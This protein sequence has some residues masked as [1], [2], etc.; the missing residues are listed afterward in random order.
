MA[1]ERQ[2]H[3]RVGLLVIVATSVCIALVIRFGDVRYVW[4][5]RYPLT[6]QLEN[7]AGLYPTASVLLS[8]LAVGTVTQIELNHRDGGVNVLVEVQEGI[9]LP[10][11]SQAVVSRSLLGETSIEFIRGT[12][13]EVLKPGSRIRG[14]AA[15]DPLVMIQRLEARTLET[16]NA[17]GE[18]GQEWR[19]VAANLNHLMET[20]RGSLDQV[21]ERAAESLHQFSITM[22]SANQMI[23]TAN[24]MVADP[25]SQQ[26]IMETL[27]ALP[28]LVNAT[29]MTIEE[30]RETVASTRQM[31]E[32]MNRNLVNLSQVTEPLGKRGEQLVSKLDSSLSKFDQFLSELNSFAK[33]VN[34]KE[35]SLQ[36]LISDP[37]LHDQLVR[38]SESANLL[39]RNLEPVLR[40]L[41]E[42]S[43]KVARNPEVLGLGGAVRPSTGLKDAELRSTAPRSS[44]APKTVV[45]GNNSSSS[46][47][48]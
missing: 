37:S 48:R 6:I 17:F 29:R 40:D 42:F 1:T 26:S 3:F 46:S 14:T 33:M 41:R 44:I 27:T 16:L 22:K 32:G 19:A 18:T 13:T 45:R 25:A 12:S 21:V 47:P 8:G 39:M 35:G 28:K 5:K 7:G 43:D 23:A 9:P 24:K 2:L 31:M 10:L 38:S 20:K 30:T 11:D 36:K 34:Q 15:A 4:S